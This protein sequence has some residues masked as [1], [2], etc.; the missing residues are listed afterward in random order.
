[1]EN[2]VCNP[3]ADICHNMNQKFNVKNFVV[4]IGLSFEAEGNIYIT[5]SKAE[6]NLEV[7]MTIKPKQ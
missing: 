6:A 2:S 3:I 4:K 5:K 7:T 1:M